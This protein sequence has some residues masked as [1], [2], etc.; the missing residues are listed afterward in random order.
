LAQWIDR[1][2]GTPNPSQTLTIRSEILRQDRRIYLQLPSDYD[3]SSRAYPM[4]VV[5]DGEWLFD[6]ARSHVRFY[7]EHQ[8]M[9]FEIPKM[10]VVGIENLDRDPDYVPT[11]DPADEPVFPTAGKADRFLAFLRDELFPLI[12]SE[13]R[14]APSRTVV[15]W[16]FGGLCALYSA[17]AMP[18]LFDAYL[19]IGPAIWWD[20]ELV[21]KRFEAATFGRPKRMVITLGAD[22][23]D[24]WVY[25][26]TNKLLA[27]LEAHPIGN[28][29][30]THLEFEGAGHS[31]GIPPA[32]GQGLRALFP[33]YRPTVEGEGFSLDDLKAHYDGLSGTWGFDVEP[34]VSVVLLS[35]QY[36]QK[37][38]QPGD[39][40]EILDWYLG[41]YEDA[42]LIHFYRG[43]SLSDLGRDEEALEA[44]QTALD[45][46]R[47]QAVSDGVYLRGFQ[48]R[49]A[50]TRGR[51]AQEPRSTP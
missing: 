2:T 13:Y 15:G 50:R 19:C 47:R 42:S 48:A 34:S 25:D 3:R 43:S 45:V 20:D 33:S 18:E 4:L 28:L 38:G 5:L 40:L 23:V 49:I 36:R 30:V 21:V 10:I 26:S 41:S 14:V 7:S 31:S 17:V 9:G 11:P 29:D 12:A 51:S 44:Y 39:A 16:S 35:A 8:A 24:G 27:Q 22:E 46:E 6:L 37:A 32:F 1:E